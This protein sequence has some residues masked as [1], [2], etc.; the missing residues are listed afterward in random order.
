MICKECGCNFDEKC[1][2]CP[3]CG[4]KVICKTHSIIIES[5]NAESLD[6]LR[7]VMQITGYTPQEAK[8]LLSNLPYTIKRTEIFDEAVEIKNKLESVGMTVSIQSTEKVKNDQADY[9]VE[10]KAQ[11]QATSLPDKPEV[12]P[13]TK[14]ATATEQKK[15]NLLKTIWNI[16][17]IAA[18]IIVA[19]IFIFGEPYVIGADILAALNGDDYI[20]NPYME[21]V[22]NHKPLNDGNTYYSAFASTFDRNDWHYFKHDGKRIVQVTSFYTDI[23]DK[24]ITQFLI[25]PSEDGESFYI[26]PYAM[27]V[28]GKDLTPS[29]MNIVLGAVFS[30]DILNALSELV[31]YANLLY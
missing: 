23:N 30:G 19:W 5:A 26:E 8:M 3:V 11:Q 18:I 27:R 2:Q 9:S 6:V 31:F 7:V 4:F 22:M 21:M 10:N 14:E 20:D 15:R 28:S 1:G 24:M 29:E 13:Q 16:I 25:T 17:E 12:N